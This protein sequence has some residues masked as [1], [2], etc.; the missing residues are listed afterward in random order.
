[1]MQSSKEKNNS[2]YLDFANSNVSDME[3][4]CKGINFPFSISNLFSLWCQET[5]VYV[6]QLIEYV[7][8]NIRPISWFHLQMRKYKL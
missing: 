7:N 1:M 8:L 3:I 5:E 2:P 6:Q 4:I